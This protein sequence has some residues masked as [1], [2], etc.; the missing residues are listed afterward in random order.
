[1]AIT[2]SELGLNIALQDQASKNADTIDKKLASI[3]DK[4]DKINNRL[5]LMNEALQRVKETQLA[6]SKAQESLV[7]PSQVEANLNPQALKDY[8][9]QLLDIYK[10]QDAAA[11][12]RRTT[13]VG[14]SGEKLKLKDI[15]EQK[16]GYEELARINYSINESNQKMIQDKLNYE[17]MYA[18]AIKEN[19]AF[20]LARAKEIENAELQRQRLLTQTYALQRKSVSDPAVQQKFLDIVDKFSQPIKS[21]VDIQ[22]FQKARQEL[23]LLQ[24]ELTKQQASIGILGRQW[25]KLRTVFARVF[26]A[27]V[28]FVIIDFSRRIFTGF[29]EGLIQS[30][31][32][33]E[34]TQARL[35]S[36]IPNSEQLT[37]VWSK[38][39]EV[40]ITTPFKLQDISLA[41]VQLKAF[42]VNIKNNIGVIADWA[43]SVNQ[44]IESVST[45]FGKI[46]Q[47]SPRTPLLLSTR[48]LSVAAFE[49]YVA[50]F[51]D[52]ATALA[53]LIEDTYGGTA[54]RVSQTFS[55]IL[56]NLSDLWQ[57]ISQ[58]IGQ[59]LFES[60]K[61]DLQTV[62]NLMSRLDRQGKSTLSTIGE[63]IN[64]FV[65]ITAFTA[66]GLVIGIVIERL[67]KLKSVLTDVNG[68]LT[69]FGKNI[70]WGLALT[71]VG[72]LIYQ[73]IKLE[74][75]FDSLAEARQKY[76]S[77]AQDDFN[78]QIEQLEIMNR[79][80]DEQQSLF[81]FILQSVAEGWNLWGQLLSGNIKSIKQFG[82]YFLHGNSK[83]IQQNNIRIEQLREEQMERKRLLAIENA[84]FDIVRDYQTIQDVNQAKLGDFFKSVSE[85]LKNQIDLLQGGGVIT[86]HP[87]FQSNEDKDLI[88]KKQALLEF[89]NAMTKNVDI[90]QIR[91]K[92][93]ESL[94]NKLLSLEK[95]EGDISQ[96]LFTDIKEIQEAIKFLLEFENKANKGAE[97]LERLRE[98]ILEL[99]E[100]LIQGRESMK[101]YLDEDIGS[102]ATKIKAIEKRLELKLKLFERKKEVPIDL[103]L[104]FDES[105][106]DKSLVDLAKKAADKYAIPREVFLRQI[107]QESMFFEKVISAKGAVGLGQLM[108]DT[109][110][111]LGLRVDKEIDERYDAAKNLEAS[112]KY[113]SQLYQTFQSWDL[114]LAAY[115]AGAGNVKKY[116]GIPKFKETIN[117]VETIL[118][119]L[120]EVNNKVSESF[121]NFKVALDSKSLIEFANSLGTVRD[122]LEKKISTQPKEI[123]TKEKKEILTKEKIELQS[124]VDIID[125]IL[126]L[127]NLR[128]S[129]EVQIKELQQQQYE[130]LLQLENT[131][132]DFNRNKTKFQFDEGGITLQQYYNNLQ[133]QLLIIHGEYLES[134]KHELDLQKNLINLTGSDRVK[135]ENDVLDE[136]RKQYQILSDQQTLV[137]EILNLPSL[138]WGDAWRKQLLKLQKDTEKWRDELADVVS[139]S[140]QQLFQDIFKHF[141]AG[142]SQD[143][144]DK[145]TELQQQLEDIRL[146]KAGIIDENNEITKIND[147]ELR[148]Q[149]EIAK[150][151][152]QRGDFLRDG[153]LKLL[154]DIESK[155][156]EMASK[157]L[158]KQ[159]FDLSGVGKKSSDKEQDFFQQIL[160]SIYSRGIGVIDKG[161][162][163]EID[164]GGEPP[165]I[166]NYGRTS[167]GRNIDMSEINRPSPTYNTHTSTQ[168]TNYNFSGDMYGYD[169]FKGKIKQVNREL[170]RN[171]I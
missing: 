136:Q 140:G 171:T 155:L 107:Q 43:T 32:L 85:D 118:G 14:I 157:E 17:K 162:P 150:I 113:L 39:K 152:K 115:N 53:K 170:T 10:A 104:S 94:R 84:Q 134:K 138:T 3:I 15:Q 20:D 110:K 167:V 123:L 34:E 122:E 126:K 27:L 169:D 120:P 18:N 106:F 56:S 75:S 108:P 8:K 26:D 98:Q 97:S 133:D 93:T 95:T 68:T 131:Q 49:S 28:S 58:T 38:L 24:Q 42:G 74:D 90:S 46:V 114:A 54:K 65:R 25:E 79:E 143:D 141:Q 153:I 6:L 87:Q 1:M 62:Y 101:E 67:I 50:K 35:K 61:S 105:R 161:T 36:L 47:F 64:S 151:E 111:D 2:S 72:A 21:Q 12:A 103:K 149:Q 137:E 48:G 139:T 13:Q 156:I 37:E 41:A 51:G 148:I 4:E 96:S 76:A 29:F 124:Q 130:K 57:F 33:L 70:G 91:E 142:V 77:L 112:A 158:M 119:K 11:S 164:Y 71:A 145:I 66:T 55:G 78:G 128:K 81:N 5:K 16:Q 60:L 22:N 80:L 160:D 86:A 45:A 69:I 19:K 9:A 40:T 31:Q 88:A 59:P 92:V 100:K 83:E 168:V 159:I 82:E 99:N 125:T 102:R 52:R 147:E 163:V 63:V 144:I 109:A 117:Y 132:R 127:L 73:I 129:E 165:N 89:T 146:R 121:N 23:A 116:G 154:N 135:A 7:K 166:D 44:D 30:N